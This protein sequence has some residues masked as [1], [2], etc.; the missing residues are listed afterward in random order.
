MVKRKTIWDVM[1]VLEGKK[2][3]T[4]YKK[5]QKEMIRQ[6]YKKKK[7]RR[8]KQ[9]GK[10]KNKQIVYSRNKRKRI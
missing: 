7:K 3:G 8:K 1:D 4:S 6:G 9:N 5:L 2:K 10:E